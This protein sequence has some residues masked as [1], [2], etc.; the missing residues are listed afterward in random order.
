MIVPA[1]TPESVDKPTRPTKLR[2]EFSP[3]RLRYPIVFDAISKNMLA[4]VKPM[5]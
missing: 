3:N 1:I 4:A 2:V 5:K